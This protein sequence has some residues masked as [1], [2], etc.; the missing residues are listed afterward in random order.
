MISPHPSIL[1]DMCMVLAAAALRSCVIDLGVDRVDHPA[2]VP[3]STLEGAATNALADDVSRRRS[4]C[5]A[6]AMTTVFL[7]ITSFTMAPAT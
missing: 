7:P 6:S 3:S 5:C 4:V 2:A 1:F